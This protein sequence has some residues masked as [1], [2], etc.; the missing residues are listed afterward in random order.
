MNAYSQDLRDS[1]IKLY[2]TGNYTKKS[3]LELFS[4]DYNTLCCFYNTLNR[5]RV[6]YKKEVKYKKRCELK[7][8]EFTERLSNID[9]K[10]TS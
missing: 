10:S 4:V 9:I 2:L 3:L 7:R 1:A 6:T 8:K 5:L